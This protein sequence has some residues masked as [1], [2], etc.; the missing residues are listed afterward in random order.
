MAQEANQKKVELYKPTSGR[1]T[2]ND[3]GDS[4]K[5]SIGDVQ[6]YGRVMKGVEERVGQLREIKAEHT[7]NVRQL[8]S[9]M[10]RGAINL[11][12]FSISL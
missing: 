9:S 8:E 1:R 4:S 11:I 3:L 10:L 5:W 7:V 6:E 12:L 2:I